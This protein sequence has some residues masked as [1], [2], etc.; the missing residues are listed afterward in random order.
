MDPLN[1]LNQLKEKYHRLITSYMK[2]IELIQKISDTCAIVNNIV[3]WEALT[4]NQNYEASQTNL[5]DNNNLYINT[6]NQ[7]QTT[8]SPSL[9]RGIELFEELAHQAEV[10]LT[11]ELTLWWSNF[12]QE[13]GFE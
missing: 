10:T 8:D 6:D 11:Q 7:L 13:K 9:A 4:Y 5:P 12:L 2:L 1:E 3:D